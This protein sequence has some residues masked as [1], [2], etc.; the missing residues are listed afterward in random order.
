M[1]RREL[2]AL[3][4]SA[5][6]KVLSSGARDVLFLFLSLFVYSFLS[7]FI[8]VK[9]LSSREGDVL[10]FL[11][12]EGEI[13]ETGAALGSQMGARLSSGVE[14]TPLYAGNKFSKV[15]NTLTLSNNYTKALTF[16]NFC[17]RC[18]LTSRHALCSRTLAESDEWYLLPL[19]P[20]PPSRSPA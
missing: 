10:V 17:Q 18:R 2:A 6:L 20:S 7:L 11:P 1:P 14:V 9:V 8:N 4:A 15:L 3:V 12:G 5:V 19:S 16:Q 13:R